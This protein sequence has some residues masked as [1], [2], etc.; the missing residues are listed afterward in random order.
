LLFIDAQGGALVNLIHGYTDNGDPFV[1]RFTDQLL[2]EVRLHSLVRRYMKVSAD[3]LYQV[4]KPFFA[5]LHKWLFSGELYDPYA[6]FFVSLDP[7]LAHV[8]YVHPSSLA[9]GIGH[10]SADGGFAG[11]GADN[12]DISSDREGGLRLWEA[13][14]QFQK[15]MLPMFVGEAFGR[16]ASLV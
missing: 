1:R 11:V 15:D 8:Q 13:K 6:E 5:T 4:S 2:E 10:L 16:K 3:L 7:E 12:E 14:Y 9:G